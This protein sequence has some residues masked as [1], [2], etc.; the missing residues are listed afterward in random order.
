MK[1]ETKFKGFDRIGNLDYEQRTFVCEVCQNNC[2]VTEIKI[3]G[4]KLFYGDRC[5]RYSGIGKDVE[6]NLPDLFKERE[7]MLMSY[8][9]KWVERAQKIGIAR[10]GFF[11]ELFP[12]WASFFNELGFNIALSQKTNKKI[13]K[14]RLEKATAEF[15]YPIKVSFGHYDDLNGKADYIFAPDIIEM[16]CSKFQEDREVRDTGWDKSSSCPY[17]QNIGFVISRTVNSRNI[18]NPHISFKQSKKQTVQELC[19]AFKSVGVNISKPRIRRAFD[20]AEGNYFEFKDRLRQRG[21]KALKDMEKDKGIVIIGRPYSSYDSAMNLNLAR[22]I[23]SY[24]FLVIP[25]DFL[26]FPREDLSKRWVNEFAIQGQHILS[27]AS[28]IKEK[29]LNAVY[30][31]YFGCGPNSFLKEFFAKEVERPFL[32]LQIDE[33]TADAGLVTRLEAFLESII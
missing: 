33:H 6:T 7:E 18:I 22:K 2:D 10:G 11:N 8:H 16:Y 26:P 12:L 30:L 3:E 25:Q 13:I 29:G 14:S 5:E 27:T 23:R 17:L 19:D 1:M 9:K 28:I 21:E 24:G 32:T 4:G 15:C 31:D 20:S